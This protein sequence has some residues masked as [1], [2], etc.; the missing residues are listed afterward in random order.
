M[1]NS[2]I[3]NSKDDSIKTFYD[4]LL[5]KIYDDPFEN[6]YAE[7]NYEFKKRNELFDGVQKY[8]N[9]P[10][11]PFYQSFV[12]QNAIHNIQI[13][14]LKFI[15]CYQ[16]SVPVIGRRTKYIDIYVIKFTILFV[17]KIS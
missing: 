1:T 5:D 14:G 11:E 2:I 7:F 12:T 3:S 15:E 4:E 16:K 9:D 13:K 17:K 10:A 8:L 6:S